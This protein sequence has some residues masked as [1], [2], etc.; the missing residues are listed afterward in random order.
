MLLLLRRMCPTVESPPF[1]GENRVHTM[2]PYRDRI[3]GYTW[4]RWSSHE[5]GR[6]APSTNSPPPSGTPVKL[7]KYTENASPA[8]FPIILVRRYQVN[9][10][11]FRGIRGQIPIN[12]SYFKALVQYWT[13][14]GSLKRFQAHRSTPLNNSIKRAG[15]DSISKLGLSH[16]RSLVTSGSPQERTTG[17]ETSKKPRPEN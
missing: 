10:G 2:L 15:A 8:E 11:P 3:T 5:T 16:H 12:T 4:S 17:S 7:Q 13:W 14:S 1:V 6:R 9:L